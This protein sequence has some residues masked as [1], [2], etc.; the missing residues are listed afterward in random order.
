[1]RRQNR[2]LQLKNKYSHDYSKYAIGELF[3]HSR[4]VALAL[5]E[6]LGIAGAF[7]V[8]WAG[9]DGPLKP[10]PDGVLAT[11]ARLDVAA[12]DAWMIGDGPQDIG[13]GK[14]AGCFTVAVPGIAERARLLASGPDLVCESL[15][16]LR[17]QLGRL[18]ARPP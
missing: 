14:A 15:H 6:P 12:A 7:D 11:L 4:N 17:E 1:M 16:D 2:N 18:T 8:L 13:A 5:L 3:K 9:G 10:A